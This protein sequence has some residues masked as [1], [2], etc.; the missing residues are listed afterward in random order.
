[1]NVCLLNDSFPPVIDGVANVVM[2]YAD[3]LTKMG[4]KVCVAT[5]AYPDADYEG[6]PYSVVAYKSIDTTEIVK[7]Y[8][9][10][11]PFDRQA[12]NKMRLFK[13]D[14]IHT[15]CP[16]ASTMMARAL[17]RDVDVP[18]VFT[19]HTKFDV[20][21]A[22]AVKA[23]T[24]QNEGAK[25]MVDNIEACDEVWTVSHGAGENLKSLGFQGDYR[26]VS[27]GVDFDKGRVEEDFVRGV[28]KEFDLPQELPIFLFVGRIMEYKG[29]PLIID[30]LKI[31]S[32]KGRDFRMVFVGGGADAEKMR[33]KAAEC[34]LSVDI[35]NEDGGIEA[36]AISDKPGKIIFAGP[37]HDRKI[38]RAWNT[39]SRLFLFPST[40][41]TNGIVVREA[42]ACGLASV[43][44]KDSC[45]AEG[46]TDG[47]NGFLID[48]DA[49]SMARVLEE[50]GFDRDLTGAAGQR[51]MDEIYISW[52]DA[53]RLAYERY[54][55]L[56]EL[57]K[58]GQLP[59]KK[60]ASDNLIRFMEHFASG[61]DMMF[62]EVRDL[63]D[64][65]MEN[66][67]ETIEEISEKRNALKQDM[68]EKK[69][70]FVEQMNEKKEAFAEQMNEKKEALAGKM[71]ETRDAIT[72]KL[73]T[74]SGGL[75]HEKD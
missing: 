17:N 51:A 18:V 69:E 27:N 67:N 14:I 53:V 6:Y 38:L 71:H 19:Y 75:R 66:F 5:P 65:M 70:A 57:K 31:L 7:G 15:H 43:L 13:P 10:G 47:V 1:M 37:E 74:K 22:R 73:L 16:V 23:K 56:V 3:V 40:Y 4:Q 26:V 11:N 59:S 12:L 61:T 36:F 28:T 30:A 55:E 72:Q 35:K 45:A 34:G 42:A 32:E 9:A 48:E 62:T 63:K 39:A 68:M 49:Q 52:S 58:S 20:D 54:E 60:E 50:C 24:L 64:G 44:I 2:N 8:R 46:I 25:I 21:I 33:K 41:D 29:L